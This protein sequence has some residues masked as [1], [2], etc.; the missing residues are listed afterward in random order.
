MP[1]PANMLSKA[2]VTL[3][4]GEPLFDPEEPDPDPVVFGAPLVD[5]PLP[6]ELLEEELLEVLKTWMY[7]IS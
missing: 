4:C 1:A 7:E 3:T 2:V 5:V 6:L